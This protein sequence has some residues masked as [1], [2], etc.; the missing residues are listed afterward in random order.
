MEVKVRKIDNC[1]NFVGSVTIRCDSE[2]GKL[3]LYN[4]KV[5]KGSKGF[6]LTSPSRK[7]SD[8]KYYSEYYLEDA[9]EILPEILKR[10][11]LSEDNK[12]WGKK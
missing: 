3:Y 9:D 11:G 7:A 6:F 2:V 1:D 8:G 12:K 4:L 10:L 5:M